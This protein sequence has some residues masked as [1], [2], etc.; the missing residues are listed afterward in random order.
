M[1]FLA[2]L[3]ILLNCHP[4]LL[5]V[6]AQVVVPRLLGK[7]SHVEGFQVE[8]APRKVP[9]AIP[10]VVQRVVPRRLDKDISAEGFEEEPVRRRRSIGPSVQG[11]EDIKL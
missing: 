10:I 6:H 8:S 7:E 9:R 11:S 5:T 1:K 4:E 2:N 3:L